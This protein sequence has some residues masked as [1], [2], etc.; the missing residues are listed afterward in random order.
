[1]SK[2]V[3]VLLVLDEN[4]TPFDRAWCCFEEAMVV[5]DAERKGDPLL[6]DIATVDGA[7]RAHVATQGPAAADQKR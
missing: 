6:L 7:G 2:C 3:G 4:A 1:M 5:R